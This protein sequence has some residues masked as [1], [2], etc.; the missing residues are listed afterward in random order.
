MDKMSKS[1]CKF[2]SGD[3]AMLE[4]R[5]R[6]LPVAFLMTAAGA[7]LGLGAAYAGM[8]N[9]QEPQRADRDPKFIYDRTCGY[10]HGHNVGPIILGRGLPPQAIEYFVRQGNGAMPA[11]RPTEVSNS[12]LASLARWI[13]EAPADN[14]EHGQ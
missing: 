9:A 8:A 12:E 5:G 6:I 14:E 1:N 10:C 13:S 11:F 7:S 2:D 3:G 4:T